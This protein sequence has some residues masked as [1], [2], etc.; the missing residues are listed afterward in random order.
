M[1][2]TLVNAAAIIAGAAI[3]SGLKTLLPDRL[4]KSV[5]TALGLITL[6]LGVSMA[7]TSSNIMAV[8]I[9]IVVGTILGEILDID[10]R[11]KGFIE[12]ISPK[13]NNSGTTENRSERFVQGFMTATL[14][15]C[16][17]SMAIL[18]A[19]ED[20]MGNTPNLLYTKS[21][22]DGISA[23][24]LASAFGLSVLF[25][26]V[27]ILLYQG[28]ITLLATGLSQVMTPEMMSDM[29]A[30]GGVLLIGLAVNILDIKEVRVTNMLPAL[31]ITPII[32]MWL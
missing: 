13:K 30:A 22:M 8:V 21:I 3:G 31:V 14:L 15:Y 5:F 29:T 23:I 4:V 20:G 7:I 2:G 12:R 16:V 28:A 11:L 26:A 17:G 18:G 19:I 10:K 25:S 24:A 27:P 1:T 32:S 6:T 9:G